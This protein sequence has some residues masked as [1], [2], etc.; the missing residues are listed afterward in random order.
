MHQNVVTAD[1]AKFDKLS[2]EEQKKEWIEMHP[3]RVHDWK[4][5]ANFQ[6]EDSMRK[7]EHRYH[8]E[9]ALAKK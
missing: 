5:F 1:L 3:G 7:R 6:R 4:T 8:L 9:A 2:F